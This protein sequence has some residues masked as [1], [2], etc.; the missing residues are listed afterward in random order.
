MI[1]GMVSSTVLT[2]SVI[3]VL[4]CMLYSEADLFT[5]WANIGIYLLIRG[6]ILS[7][8]KLTAIHSLAS[9]SH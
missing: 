2:L 8:C 5:Q 6:L 4:Y 9:R 3:P 7:R 1:G